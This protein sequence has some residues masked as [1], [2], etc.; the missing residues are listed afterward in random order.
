MLDIWFGEI[1]LTTLVLLLT[2]FVVLPVQIFLCFRVKHLFARLL[3]VLLLSALLLICIAAGMTHS[4][5]DTLGY[6][7][8][9]TLTGLMLLPC[10]IVWGIWAIVQSY[11]KK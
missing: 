4:G 2:L 3:P 6:T 1:E 9:A 11:K 10:G 8:L 7:L 5:W